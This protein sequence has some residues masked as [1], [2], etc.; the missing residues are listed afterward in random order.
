LGSA[1]AGCSSSQRTRNSRNSATGS[2]IMI[3]EKSVLAEEIVGSAEEWLWGFDVKQLRDLVALEEG[4]VGIDCDLILRICFRCS[5]VAMGC[6]FRS[7][8]RT[9]DGFQPVA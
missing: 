2:G 7:L 4:G 9:S 6:H 1:R 8:K 3:R 5:S